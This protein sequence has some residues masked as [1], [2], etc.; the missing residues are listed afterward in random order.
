MKFDNVSDKVYMK[1]DEPQVNDLFVVVRKNNQQTPYLIF[2]HGENVAL[3][4][5]HSGH[6]NYFDKNIQDLIQQY[7]ESN[8]DSFNPIKEYFFVKSFKAKLSIEDTFGYKRL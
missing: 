4:N 6:S 3:V 8:K 5:L 1:S 7:L 2:S